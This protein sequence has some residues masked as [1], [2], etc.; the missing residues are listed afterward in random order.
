MNIFNNESFNSGSNRIDSFDNLND[1]KEELYF[2]N[3]NFNKGIEADL[4][5]DNNR[6]FFIET[7]LTSNNMLSPVGLNFTKNINEMNPQT[8]IIQKMKKFKKI[9]IY[10]LIKKENQ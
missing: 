4:M 6:L 8:L 2:N 3:Y 5:T 9:N 10:L 7:S 1:E